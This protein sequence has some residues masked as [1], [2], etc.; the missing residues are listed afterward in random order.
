[1][2]DWEGGNRYAAELESYSGAEPLPL[3]E[4]F[5]ARGRVLAALGRDAQRCDLIPELHR[6]ITEA[7]RL[8]L[9]IALPTLRSALAHIDPDAIRQVER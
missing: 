9:L 6:L 5:V 2:G 3:T 1:M 8:G 4:F 7:E